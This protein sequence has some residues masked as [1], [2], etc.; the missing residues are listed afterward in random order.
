MKKYEKRD[1]Y[2]ILILKKLDLQ[3]KI[4]LTLVI[5][6]KKLSFFFIIFVLLPIM[7]EEKKNLLS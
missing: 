1:N 2:V 4:N 3:P 6:M 7:S 5:F